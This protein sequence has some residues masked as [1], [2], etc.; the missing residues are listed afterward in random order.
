MGVTTPY[1]TCSQKIIKNAVKGKEKKHGNK[2]YLNLFPVN[3]FSLT[4][5][6]TSSVFSKERTSIRK[7]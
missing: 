7:G 6:D 3:I 5:S 4:L 1:N 2:E